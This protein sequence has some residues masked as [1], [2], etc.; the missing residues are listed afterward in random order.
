VATK[1]K[2]RLTWIWTQ[3]FAVGK[4]GY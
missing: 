2:E 4:G 1:N 3:S